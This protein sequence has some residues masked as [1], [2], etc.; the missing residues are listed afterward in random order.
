MTEPSGQWGDNAYGQ[1]GDGTTADRNDPVQAIHTEDAYAVAGGVNHTIIH[2]QN[3]TVWTWG[4]N[5]FGQLGGTTQVCHFDNLRFEAIAGG[6]YHSIAIKDD[7]T[8]WT[9]G[10]NRYGQLGDGTE[11][12]LLVQAEIELIGLPSAVIALRIVSGMT[13]KTLVNDISGDQKVGLEEAVYFLLF[14]ADLKP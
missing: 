7:G 12:W 13:P 14:A 9:W 2:K 4:N 11:P 8:V 5:E 1:L 10:D 6:G 3:G